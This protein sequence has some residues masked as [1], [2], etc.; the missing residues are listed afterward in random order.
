MHDLSTEAM[1]QPAGDAGGRFRANR[2]G[3]AGE[4]G[5]RLFGAV[6]PAMTLKASHGLRSIA[7]PTCMRRW[8]GLMST[9]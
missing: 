6:K 9:T 7:S 8:N 4:S 2:F 5:E 1:T 3:L